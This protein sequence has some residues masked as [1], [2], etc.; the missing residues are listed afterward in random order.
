[1]DV[2][3][4]D[5]GK[6]QESLSFNWNGEMPLQWLREIYRRVINEMRDGEVEGKLM[7]TV[8]V[9]LSCAACDG[10]MWQLFSN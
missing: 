5:F 4:R 1:M 2:K 9:S 10:R 3:E 8:A 6:W 7:G